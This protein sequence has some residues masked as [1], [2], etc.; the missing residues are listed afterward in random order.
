MGFSNFQILGVFQLFKVLFIR[1]KICASHVHTPSGLIVMDA[2]SQEQ[3]SLPPTIKLES[4]AMVKHKQ[5]LALDRFLA[6]GKKLAAAPLDVVSEH[7]LSSTERYIAHAMMNRCRPGKL[8]HVGLALDISKT[9]FLLRLLP[10]VVEQEL[11]VKTLS[12]LL[13]VD[14]LQLR[15]V[16]VK[17]LPIQLLQVG[18]TVVNWH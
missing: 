16:G 18:L 4:R 10:L 2:S 17:C 6:E 9:F 12:E 11:P 3:A 14:S 8:Y 7:L 15:K 5:S 13:L 1:T